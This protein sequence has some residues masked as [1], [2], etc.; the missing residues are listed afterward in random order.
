[1]FLLAAGIIC[2]ILQRIIE[3]SLIL[4]TY[5]WLILEHQTSLS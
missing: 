2:V 3:K 4:K 5:G 1:V